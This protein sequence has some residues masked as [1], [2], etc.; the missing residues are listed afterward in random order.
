[1]EF[2]SSMK[3]QQRQCTR[4]SNHSYPTVKVSHS[5]VI[6]KIIVSAPDSQRPRRTFRD[7]HPG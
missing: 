2:F 4:G 1:M 3:Y 7:C 6:L 5:R